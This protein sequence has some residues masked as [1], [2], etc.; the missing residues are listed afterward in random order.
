MA[1]TR[2]LASALR[3]GAVDHSPRALTGPL[4]HV[5]A[6]ACSRASPE[7]SDSGLSSCSASFCAPSPVGSAASGES[8]PTSDVDRRLSASST[9]SSPSSA[10]SKSTWNST[11]SSASRGSFASNPLAAQFSRESLS[12]YSGLNL[13]LDRDEED[14]I[15]MEKLPMIRRSRYVS[16]GSVATSA[17][18]TWLE[19]L[20]HRLDLHS[21]RVAGLRK[22]I[23]ALGIVLMVLL[24]LWTNSLG[25][26]EQYGVL[27]PVRPSTINKDA[28]SSGSKGVSAKGQPQYGGDIFYLNTKPNPP[29]REAEINYLAG[30]RIPLHFTSGKS[31]HES[32]EH[33][34]NVKI[35]RR[36]G[37]IPLGGGRKAQQDFRGYDE[38]QIIKYDSPQP[39]LRSQLKAGW[40]YVTSL[41]SG[42]HSQQILSDIK[43]L[44]FALLSR[45]A[46]ILPTLVPVMIDDG[47]PES[48]THFYD[49]HRLM[50]NS[51]LL[52]V[53]MTSNCNPPEAS[54]WSRNGCWSSQEA[55]IGSALSNHEPLNVH[56]VR[57][58]HWALPTLARGF[59]GFGIAFPALRLFDANLEAKNDW[60]NKARRLALPQK[61]LLR[62]NGAIIPPRDKEARFANR[63]EEFDSRAE[64]DA[65]PSEQLMC[66]DNP[67]FLA[68]VTTRGDDRASGDVEPLAQEDQSW[69][70]VGRHLRFNALVEDTVDE[71]L[72][73]MFGVE[74]R[75]EVPP[76]IAVHVRGGGDFSAVVG[77]H[78]S[79]DKY[80]SAL[81]TLQRRMQDRAKA[82]K[83]SAQR[84][85]GHHRALRAMAHGAQADKLEIVAT[86]DDSGFAHTLHELGWRVVDHDGMRT[87][88][89]YGAWWPTIIDSAILARGVGFVGTDRSSFSQLAGLRVKYWH[90][91]LVEFAS[92]A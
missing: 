57:V 21:A 26:S 4:S 76:F 37:Q 32:Q 46:A 73:R 55:A 50:N 81:H 78:L 5:V 83:H 15:M 68:P 1:S 20:F 27:K 80:S 19:W 66:I 9:S 79:V 30:D 52:A 48:I 67:A 3:Y 86:T 64:G 49:L 41:N 18:S 39:A 10:S 61:T 29:P 70:L 56:A 28:L 87:T 85:A 35:G 12:G 53:S 17:K 8:T 89:H 72:M 62:T 33:L 74:H 63:K 59:E 91:G 69:K 88:Q 40:R 43:L 11:R 24:I 92:Y 13:T 51:G 84:D 54:S 38:V 22:L 60:I 2:Y 77:G 65:V 44:Y 42:G 90:H 75:R 71:Y 25:A 23:T 82:M 58:T 34:L 6:A 14:G 31:D 7:G 47:A 36:G 45:R 16:P